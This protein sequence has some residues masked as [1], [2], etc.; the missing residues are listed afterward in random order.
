MAS[1]G[2]NTFKKQYMILSTV[3]TDVIRP[4]RPSFK[5]SIA[6]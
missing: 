5:L 6:E 2:Q 3:R 1:Q 4:V